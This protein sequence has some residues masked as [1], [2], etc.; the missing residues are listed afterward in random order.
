[1]DYNN[2]K[3]KIVVKNFIVD[4]ILK[5][6]FKNEGDK[7]MNSDYNINNKVVQAN[8]FIQQTNWTLKETQLKLLKVFI[9]CIDT[10]H[11]TGTVN[12]TKK[13]LVQVLGDD[14]KNHYTYLI[15]QIR[16]LQT[17]IKLYEDEKKITYVSL[18]NDFTWYKESEF[19]TVEFSKKILPYLI[20]LNERFL[21]YDV[22]NV[23]GFNSKYGLILYEYLLSRERQERDKDHE[24]FISLNDLKR[25]TG[26]MDKY[27]RVDAFE[28]KIVKVAM[29]DIN[30]AN[31]EFLMK[32]EK[33]KTGRNIIGIKFM[34]RKRTSYIETEFDEI[35]NKSYSK[36]KI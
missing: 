30:N 19:V 26:T 5:K 31:V 15:N 34:L 22:Y 32:Y 4:M 10:K 8:Q 11:P 35:K 33:V 3:K 14:Y 20:D 16:S 24:Y 27:E 18:I 21:Q 6:A 36:Q 9:S 1:M 12:I 17:S 25:L 13:E 23:R 7:Q 29:K 28:R 2:L